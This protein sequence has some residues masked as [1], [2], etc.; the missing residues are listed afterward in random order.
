MPLELTQL[1]ERVEKR[2][3]RAE[4]ARAIN[5]EERVRFHVL[6]SLSINEYSKAR[7]EFLKWCKGL[8]SKDAYPSFEQMVR[9]PYPTVSLY[10][11]VF[12]AL[13]KV[14][15]GKDATIKYQFA[16]ETAEEDWS[17]YQAEVLDDP[18][19]FK[20]LAFE[21]L[22]SEVNSMIIVDMDSEAKEPN[23]YYYFLSVDQIIHY[24]EEEGVVQWVIFKSATDRLVVIDDSSYR[25]FITE[26]KTNIIKGEEVNNPHDLGYCPAS[27]F[28]STSI[29]PNDN[30][31][32]HPITSFLA[33]SDL[34]LLGELSKR[35]LD[36]YAATP[37]F[38]GY[39]RDC[40]YEFEGQECNGGYLV[41]P[42]GAVVVD[43]HPKPCPK[44]STKKLGPGTFVTVPQ[45]D[46]DP[47]GAVADMRE[48][49]G[50]IEIPVAGLNYNVEEV[51][52]REK[53][54]YE[55][56]TGYGCDQ[57][58]NQ[59]VNVE[60]VLA[61]IDSRRSVLINLKKNFE[62][63]HQWVTSTMCRLRY[64]Q[65]GSCAYVN[66]GTQFYFFEPSLP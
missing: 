24:E 1:K 29:K 7:S 14:L 26:D 52:R 62:K 2:P 39:D 19:R 17:T 36:T 38:W 30:V 45:P 60:Q 13:E 5:Y 18:R 37:I 12:A 22:K 64:G 41:D 8:L 54:I 34:Y 15:D 4:L 44:C 33:D 63:A 21:K 31:K 59:A 46:P 10:D 11:R 28:W 40:D 6:P 48:P 23:P 66:Y 32:R 47:M 25:V 51:A 56:I 3:K 61:S 9:P 58:E 55:G 65:G 43:G 27:W 16:S 53:A 35:Y 50:V 57:L 20:A 49:I 42:R